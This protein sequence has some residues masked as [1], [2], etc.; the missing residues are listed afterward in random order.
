VGN[1]CPYNEKEVL[2]GIADGREEAFEQLVSHYK[3][4]I[5][6]IAL[7]LSRS[8]VLSEDIVQD[9]FLKIWI[10]RHTLREIHNFPAYL[11]KM[12]ENTAFTILQRLASDRERLKKLHIVESYLPENYIQKE[13]DHLFHRA[14][15][16]LPSRQQQVFQLVKEKGMKREEAAKLLNISAETVKYHLAQ[17]IQSIRSYCLTHGDMSQFLILA[18]AG[19]FL[20]RDFF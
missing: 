17:A 13:Y 15:L 18:I 6:T 7:R 11:N 12:I 4:H 9:I 1:Y 3:N 14:V 16:Q 20:L 5:Y 19:A 2:S 10:R 8:A